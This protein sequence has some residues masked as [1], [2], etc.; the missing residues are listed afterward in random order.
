MT[1]PGRPHSRIR[2]NMCVT[3]PDF[4]RDWLKDRVR[5]GVAPSMS[6]EIE[7]AITARILSTLSAEDREA[8]LEAL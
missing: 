3:L 4:Q 8:V 6:A 1:Q 2:K 7:A 5:T